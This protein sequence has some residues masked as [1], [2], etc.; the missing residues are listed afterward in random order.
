MRDPVHALDKKV[1]EINTLIRKVDGN[2]IR[3]DV[4]KYVDYLN[5]FRS[6]ETGL[7]FP[8]DLQN[9]YVELAKKHGR[10]IET[11][12]IP[13]KDAGTQESVIVRIIGE[14]SPK[15]IFIVGSHLDTICAHQLYC[16]IYDN[17]DREYGEDDN[18]S[19]T[20]TNFEVFRVIMENNIRFEKTV[21]F[22]AYA[23]EEAGIDG[24]RTVARIYMDERNLDVAA[25]V[26]NDMVLYKGSKI[27]IMLDY[28]NALNPAMLKLGNTYLTD[29]A[30]IFEGNVN[31]RSDNLRWKNHG[32]PTAF[33]WESEGF[34]DIHTP[35]DYGHG[36]FDYEQAAVFGRLSLL[37]LLHFAG[38]K[39]N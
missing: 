36:L 33:P 18:A 29:Q 19:G 30:E 15:E 38:A 2:R 17:M 11:E 23:A 35:H 3:A 10:E 20:A 39:I 1:D 4:A 25:M 5:R 34:P 8:K 22:H 9:A 28:D 31:G 21:E 24:S 16:E 26:Q 12:L 6:S 27:Q 14:T 37:Y 7:Q 13:W 32:V